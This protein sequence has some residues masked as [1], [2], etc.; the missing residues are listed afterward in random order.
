MT[1]AQLRTLTAVAD[2][3][4][5]V[6]A[7]EELHV[8]QPA[9]SAAVAALARE[10][11]APLVARQGRGLV[12]TP[13]GATLARYGAR[14]LGLLDEALEASRAEAGVP[15]L[16]RLAAVTTAGE[17]VLP[18]LLAR[19]RER[20]PELG[21]ALEVAP[22]D[23]VWRL[24]GDHA[25]DL[26]VAGRPPVGAGVVTLGRWANELVVV[27]RP[28]VAGE[29]RRSAWL[30]REPG[31][32]TR[33]TTEDLLDELGIDPPR[34]T[35]GSNRAALAGAAAGLG[36][37]LAP[38]GEVGGALAIAAVPGTPLDRPYYLVGHPELPAAAKRFVALA[39][40]LPA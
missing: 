16:L 28:D 23:R 7:A 37:T 3:G 36:V 11:G 35:L 39:G 33:A 5:V 30:L 29:W 32:G 12:L 14:V 34:L 22:R 6:G 24:L 25:V 13:A 40:L 2:A 19:F 9:V 17:L 1:P 26:A 10:V 18:P 31:S 21:V 15:A 20:H 27:G 8:S 38:R 4:S